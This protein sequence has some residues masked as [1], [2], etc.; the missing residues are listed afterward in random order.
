[1]L[2]LL[3]KL[4]KRTAFILG[5]VL[6]FSACALDSGPPN[7]FPNGLKG[8]TP[9]PG[10][11]NNPTPGQGQSGT[12]GDGDDSPTP[13]ENSND[14]GVD[15]LADGGNPLD[16]ILVCPASEFEAFLDC[17]NVTCS[18][19]GNFDVGCAFLTCSTYIGKLAT[20]DCVTCMTSLI[21]GDT[22]ALADV[23]VKEGALLGD[24]GT[25][26]PF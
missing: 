6:L 13:S 4:M 3:P 1:M 10:T 25:T 8:D 15:G 23:C 24:A 18:P 17:L 21:N 16:D 2:R 11:G 26:L 5:P 7:I 20:P 14:A 22:S 9:A 19:G 12:D